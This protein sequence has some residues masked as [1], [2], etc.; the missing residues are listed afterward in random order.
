[1]RGG[2]IQ[3]ARTHLLLRLRWYAV[4][5]SRM[6]PEDGAVFMK[7]MEA[8]VAAQHPPVTSDDASAN[9]PEKTFPLKRIFQ[10]LNIQAAAS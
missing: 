6:K 3:R 9:L 8:M 1:M 5:R 2:A 7:A 10:S 4:L